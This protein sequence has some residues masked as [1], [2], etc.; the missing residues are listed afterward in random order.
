ML[1]LAQHL[2]SEC[3]TT[4]VS[5]SEGGLAELFIDRVRKAGFPWYILANDMP[6]LWAAYRELL[7]L[8]GTLQPD[9]VCCHGYKAGIIGRLATRRAG[10]P[11]IAVS[12]GWTSESWK[13][14]LYDQLDKFNLRFFDHVVCVSQGQADKVLRC[15]VSPGKV[16]VIHNA[17]DTTRFDN[18][19]P[20]DRQQLVDRFKT[21]VRFVVGSAGRLSPEKGFSVLIEAAAQVA[22][23]DPSVGFIVYGDGPLRADLQKQVTAAGLDG[24]FILAGFEPNVDRWLP[25]FDVFV[26]PSYT[27]GLANVILEAFAAKVPV[28][29]TAVGGTPE[30]VED[31]VTG[32]LV[33]PGQPERIAERVI[34]LLNRVESRNAFSATAYDTVCN[35]FGFSTQRD[36]YLQ[37]IEQLSG[38]SPILA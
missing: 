5:F 2:S 26:N 16:S 10:L 12:R 37:L 22:R 23:Q 30:L 17:I 9:V 6:R 13:I 1:G 15:G 14:R 4:F 38:R 20:Q 8:L 25:H 32:Y 19:N 35:D 31:G 29:A 34:A 3:S 11:V 33:S 24:R 36:K 27:E 18:V 7:T 21:P 28:V